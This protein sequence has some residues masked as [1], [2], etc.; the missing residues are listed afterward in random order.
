[1]IA[2]GFFPVIGDREFFCLDRLA[3]GEIVRAL[4][5][6]P[7]REDLWVVLSPRGGRWVCRR[8]DLSDLPPAE[9][10]RRLRDA[11]HDDR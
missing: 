11:A 9:L 3:G 2:L 10:F 6:V 7:G 1:M 8:S 4:E 5:P